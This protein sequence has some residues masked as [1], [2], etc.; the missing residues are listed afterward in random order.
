MG[1]GRGA[2]IGVVLGMSLPHGDGVGRMVLSCTRLRG[3][4]AQVTTVGY[5]SSGVA[6]CP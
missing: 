4:R 1:I 2:R 6:F 5:V 3:I